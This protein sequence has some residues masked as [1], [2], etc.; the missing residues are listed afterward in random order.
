[1]RRRSYNRIGFEIKPAQAIVDTLKHWGFRWDPVRR[2]WYA[3]QSIAS[4]TVV[5]CIKGGEI[6]QIGERVAER[7]M[8]AENGII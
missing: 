6:D 8:E 7:Q 5:D 1:M 3:G 2:D 4:A